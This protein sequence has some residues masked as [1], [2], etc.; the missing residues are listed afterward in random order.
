MGGETYDSKFTSLGSSYEECRAEC[1]GLY[2][3]VD[4]DVLNIFNIDP[5]EKQDVI[6]TNWFSLCHAAINGVAMYSQASGEWKQAHSQARFVI[7][8]VLQEAGE[9]FVS[10]KEVTGEDGKPDL[11][12]TMDKT[13]L[14]SVGKPAIGQFLK[15]L[16]VFK[17]LGDFASANA[18][19]SKYS[20]VN[21]Q[22]LSWRDIVISR[23][24]P[25]KMQVQA[26]TFI[27]D[28]KLSLKDYPSTH[29]GVFQSWRERWDDE[30][31][32]EID[33]ILKDLAQKDA[34]HFSF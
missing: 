26:N 8:Q 5:Q 14:E 11:L 22:W 18:M 3:S 24:Q 32:K 4:D 28:E 1:V 16:Q 17:S 33:T 6:Y 10:V 31:T 25:R 7:L 13:K 2:L 34:K 23:K 29:E 15:K 12:L 19:F 21:E 20:K 30:E 9:N 27:Q